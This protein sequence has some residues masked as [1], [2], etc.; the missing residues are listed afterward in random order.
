[1]YA[2][3]GYTG[4]YT[5][6]LTLRGLFLQFLTFF[7]NTKVE[8]SYGYIYEIGDYA[9]VSYHWDSGIPRKTYPKESGCHH[10]RECSCIKGFKVMEELWKSAAGPEN[11]IKDVSADVAA[12]STKRVQGQTMHRI[13]HLNK[14]WL[15]TFAL[16]SQWKCTKCPYGSPSLTHH[17]RT[18]VKQTAKVPR[19]LLQ[20]PSVCTFDILTDDALEELAAHLPSES[21]IS[22]S[23]AYPRFRAIV[24]SF[25]ILLRRELR[26]F[27]LRIPLNEC[28][29]GIGIGI[30]AGARTLSSDFDW[31]SLEAFD[32][33]KVRTS[34]EKRSMDYFLPLA[35]N[36]PH[37]LRAQADIKKRLGV[38]DNG[39]RQAELLINKRTGRRSNR[40]VDPP[41]KPYQ[42]VEV[43][44]RMMNTIVVSLMKSC[45]DT[46]ASINGR[47][48]VP[49]LLFASEKA[50]IS[51]CHLLHLL[52]CLCRS[53][54]PI[55]Q[56]ATDKLRKFIDNP[57]SRVKTETPD[58][59]ELIVL[60]TLVLVMPPIDKKRPITWELIRGKFLEEAIT[61]NV[62]WVLD[63]SPELQVMESGASDYR[64]DAT[65]KNSITSLRLIMFQVTFLNLF[66][67][68]YASDIG[69]LDDN[70]GFA[71]K[72]LPETMVREIKAIY[73]VDTWPQFFERVKW[74]KRLSKEAFSE[75]LRSTVKESQRRNY[76]KPAPT[77]K[78]AHYRNMRRELDAAK[79]AQS[80][81][82]ANSV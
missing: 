51:Y 41:A 79:R 76:H 63:T 19:S 33:Y 71:A 38:I 80:G 45:N 59:G 25:H 54:P 57:S 22:L 69:R 66:L 44:Y 34:I 46:L 65:F 16:I 50:V 26:C 7:S 15:S 30:D 14:K 36:R 17:C 49:T 67:H 37:F 82:V 47:S 73:K 9:T 39:L 62:R 55:L 29:L 40:R 10:L 13:E 6:A 5:P 68:T 72:E 32:D 23:I 60:I 53:T 18:P 12:H 2:E 27:F 42:T 58:L 43:L 28:I 74:D 61:R 48:Q 24:A 78:M 4:G 75:M 21:L 52:M 64:L 77:A 56:D 8:Q 1:M 35:F 3:S 11:T 31:L 70:Y 81:E 20:H